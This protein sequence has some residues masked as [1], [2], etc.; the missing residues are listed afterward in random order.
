M[1]TLPQL[2]PNWVPEYLII[3]QIGRGGYA[4][5]YLG[6]KNNE[7]YAIKVININKREKQI[8]NEINILKYLSQPDCRKDIICFVEA[9]KIERENVYV[10]ITNYMNQGELQEYIYRRYKIEFYFYK[11]EYYEKLY[12]YFEQMA[13]VVN[14]LHK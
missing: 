10:I 6:Q 11:T 5:V 8:S 9:R 4:N 1:S 14:E 12:L 3:R 7:Y 2:N 13:H